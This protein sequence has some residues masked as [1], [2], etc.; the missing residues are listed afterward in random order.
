[1]LPRGPECV[2]ASRRAAA[3]HNPAFGALPMPGTTPAR[4]RDGSGARLRRASEHFLGATASPKSPQGA[5]GPRR[6]QHGRRRHLLVSAAWARLRDWLFFCFIVMFAVP[7]ARPEASSPSSAAR[8]KRAAASK[9]STT[10]LPDAID[11]MARSLLAGH[12]MNSVIELIAEQ[13]PEPLAF[14]VRAGLPAAEARPAL[15][16]RAAADGGSRTP[17]SDLQFLITAILVQKET[18]G[19]LTEILDRASHVIRERVRIEGEVRTRTAQGRLTGWILGAASGHHARAD[20]HR[21]P[22]L[23]HHSLPRSRGQKL[24]YRRGA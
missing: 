14:R 10:A 16:R 4:A 3:D 20:Q 17:S 1:M 6:Q 7:A 22:G 21:H 18:G 13:S 24:L 11:L 23:L 12:S 8:F 19:D 5:A 9:R 2:R 15:P